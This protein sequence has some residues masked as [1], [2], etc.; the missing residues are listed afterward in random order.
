ML[1]TFDQKAGMRYTRYLFNSSFDQ[2]W[3]KSEYEK[4]GYILVRLVVVCSV[5]VLRALT[6]FCSRAPT[7]CKGTAW[8]SKRRE[9]QQTILPFG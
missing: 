4:V 3:P 1:I 2:K 5:F 8:Y 9:V 6:S 7:V